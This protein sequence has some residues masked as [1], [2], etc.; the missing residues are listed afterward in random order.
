MRDLRYILGLF[1]V[2]AVVC[3]LSAFYLEDDFDHRSGWDMMYFLFTTLSTVGYGDM[4]PKT[5]QARICA[6]VAMACMTG[7]QWFA[8]YRSL[9]D[10]PVMKIPLN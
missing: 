1:A 7:V 5:R 9:H 3:T 8:L 4:T 2:A 10:M 6:T